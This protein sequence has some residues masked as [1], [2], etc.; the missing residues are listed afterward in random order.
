MSILIFQHPTLIRHHRLFS[1]QKLYFQLG[2]LPFANSISGLSVSRFFVLKK[3][4]W[5]LM[6]KAITNNEVQFSSKVFDMQDEDVKAVSHDFLFVIRTNGG[7]KDNLFVDRSSHSSP[8]D[9]AFMLWELRK[10]RPCLRCGSDR[11]TRQCWQSINWFPALIP[12]LCENIQWLDQDDPL[13]E[14]VRI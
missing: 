10:G 3:L 13:N 11:P 5:F 8:L 9:R 14:D 2:F 7:L 12:I 1:Q 4:I 6:R